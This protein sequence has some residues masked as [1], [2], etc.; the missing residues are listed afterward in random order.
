MVCMVI[1]I[2]S[3]CVM[4]NSCDKEADLTEVVID[5]EKVGCVKTLCYLGDTLDADV[6]PDLATTV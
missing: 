2:E 5:G 1:I 3:E 4:R 6:G